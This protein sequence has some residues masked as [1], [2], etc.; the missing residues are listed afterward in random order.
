MLA[1]QR[2]NRI[3]MAQRERAVLITTLIM[4]DVWPLVTKRAT[5]AFFRVAQ[6]KYYLRQDGRII[7]MNNAEVYPDQPTNT[8][9]GMTLWQLRKI[10]DFVQN[11]NA[12]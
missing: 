6:A 3:A 5:V 2:N 1:K 8:L 11:I 12:A 10:V 4:L 9:T 7:H